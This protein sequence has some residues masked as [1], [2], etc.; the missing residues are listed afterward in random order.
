[1]IRSYL[2]ECKNTFLSEKEGSPKREDSFWGKVRTKLCEWHYLG[3]SQL[4]MYFGAKSFSKPV[5]FA[6]R[7][8]ET[9]GNF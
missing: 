2:L 9:V 5:S 4:K 3:V 1:M 7:Q 8:A 6:E